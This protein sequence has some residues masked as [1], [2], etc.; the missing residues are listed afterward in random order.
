MILAW[1]CLQLPG[2]AQSILH[3]EED[4]PAWMAT[5]APDV[6]PQFHPGGQCAYC[7]GGGKT[8]KSSHGAGEA[9]YT[10]L[11]TMSHVFLKGHK[12]PQ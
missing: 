9:V 6:P 5:S 7:G 11:N 12:D 3:G 10:G 1:P 8:E 4:W 2:P